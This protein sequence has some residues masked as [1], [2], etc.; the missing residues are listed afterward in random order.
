MARIGDTKE[1]CGRG[2]WCSESPAYCRIG[3]GE[4]HNTTISQHY[5]TL[6][7]L[8]EDNVRQVIQL[9]SLKYIL[10]IFYGR[11]KEGCE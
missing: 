3:P 5:C 4:I 7:K 11:V 2:D 1:T 8:Q 9:K 10:D 6:E